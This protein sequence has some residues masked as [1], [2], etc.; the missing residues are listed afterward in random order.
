MKNSTM[1]TIATLLLSMSTAGL[2]QPSVTINVKNDT[3]CYCKSGNYPDYTSCSKNSYQAAPI[4]SKPF[5]SK[6]VGIEINPNNTRAVTEPIQSQAQSAFFYMNA[7]S[8]SSKNEIDTQMPAQLQTN[9][10]GN[11]TVITTP[12]FMNSNRELAFAQNDPC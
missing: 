11:Y 10:G 5:N 1:I 2:T 8:T 7:V 3:A 4:Y 12:G 6:M 9:H